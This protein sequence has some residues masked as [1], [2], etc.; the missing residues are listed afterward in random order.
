MKRI[1][2]I[3]SAL[4]LMLT[5]CKEVYRYTNDTFFAM[6]TVVNTIVSDKIGESTCTEN[7]LSGIENR[8]SRTL[9]DSEISLLNSGKDVTLSDDTQ[10]V[11]ERALQI[12]KDTGYA[13]N[14]CMGTLTDLWDITSGKNVVPSAEKINRALSF[15]DA[16]SVVLS[17]GKVQVPDGMKIDLGGVAKGYALQKAT[18]SLEKEAKSKGVGADFCISLGGNVSVSGTSQ[19]MKNVGKKGWNVGITNPFDKSETAASINLTKGYVSVSGAYER[20]FEKGGRIYHH[21][22]DPKTGYP[23]ESDLASAA[24]I[25]DDGLCA[26]ALSTALFV[27]GLEGSVDFYKKSGYTFDAILITL[28]GDVYVTEGLA[29][30]FE[31]KEDAKQINKEKVIIIER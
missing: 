24:V 31:L 17:D 19:S 30:S 26:D 27:M 28:D 23:S 3:V 20:Y 11:I 13:F 9:P 1:M 2:C 18:E 14:P 16:S 7:I 5:S 29:Q 21:I 6:N 4:L 25:S 10:I 22:F 8:M 15:C 12:A